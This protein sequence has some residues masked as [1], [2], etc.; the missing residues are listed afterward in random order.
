MSERTKSAADAFGALIGLSCALHCA[1][2]AA[3]PALLVWGG[4]AWAQ[5]ESVEWGLTAASVSFSSVL[6]ALGYKKHASNSTLAL[7]ALG[8]GAL[9]VGRL[10][11]SGGLPLSPVF[12]IGGGLLLLGAHL[13][14][15]QMRRAAQCA[16]PSPA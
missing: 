16:C 5:S 3:L 13:R 4:L 11:E 8:L 2:V 7:F 6:A 10:V 15:T 9:L 1:A 14:N 12:S